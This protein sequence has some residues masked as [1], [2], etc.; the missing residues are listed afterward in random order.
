MREYTEIAQFERY[1]FTVIVDRTW[2]E[3]H[4]S[5]LFDTGIDPETGRPY[6]DIADMCRRIDR[7]D[8]EWFMMRVRVLL[9]G[10]EFG[11]AYL[12]GMLYDW[13]RVTD[14]LTDGTAEDLISEA[15]T[16]ARRE[17]NR[18]ADRIWIVQ[19]ELEEHNV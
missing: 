11:S 7:G 19:R 13:N 4:P 6:W 16:Q 18:L 17:I 14:V 3:L 1:G 5:E 10:H 9:D 15:F 12:G 8:L 2:E